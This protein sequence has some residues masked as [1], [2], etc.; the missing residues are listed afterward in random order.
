MRPSALQEMLTL[1]A[2]PDLIS[3]ALGL[4]A[5]DLF[6]ARGIADAVSRLMDRNPSNL[7]YGPPVAELRAFVARLMERR[8][9]ACDPERVFLTAGAQQGMSLISRLL[10]DG[11]ATVLL[12][13]HCYTGFQQAI[14]A[15]TPHVV[16]V[17]ASLETGIDLDAVERAIETGPRPALLYTMADGHNPLGTSM[18]IPARL[19]LVEIARTHGI[20]IL[21]DDAY[22]MISYDGADLPALRAFDGDWIFYLGSFSKT[23]APALRTGWVVVPEQFLGPL[24]TLKESSDINTATLGQRAVAAFV[25]SGFDAHLETIR[26][27]YGRRR[28]AMFEALERRLPK[29]T[30]WSSPRAGFFIWVELPDGIDAVR[31]L[32]T[33]IEREKVAFLPGAAFTAGS[34]VP[35]HSSLRLSFSF[36][37]PETIRE[38]V[39]RIARMLDAVAGSKRVEASRG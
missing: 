2:R 19:R 37:D 32:E 8:H 10:L 21:E 6:P 29:G 27:E 12:E 11:G 1:T 38:G 14:A 9:V 34:A 5:A 31:L 15:S 39:A 13:E 20:P 17:P 16:T 24:A 33:A 4:P 18:P 7:Q 35:A 28:D 36:C 22:G 3:L 23:L 25:A 30:R 26:A